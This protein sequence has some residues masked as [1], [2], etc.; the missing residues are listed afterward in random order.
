MQVNTRAENGQTFLLQYQ[1]DAYTLA[2]YLLANED[3]AA[4]TLEAVFGALKLQ[5]G[6]H[7]N[8]LRLE[9]FRRVLAAVQPFIRLG[10]EGARQNDLSCQLS[11]LDQDQRAALILV[12]ILGLDYAQACWV[13]GVS[14]KIASRLVAAGRVGLSRQLAPVA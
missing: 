5:R 3:H 10:A 12:D 6:H 2:Y 11:Q 4:A 14:Q 1:D 7:P 13:L 9:I 8:Q